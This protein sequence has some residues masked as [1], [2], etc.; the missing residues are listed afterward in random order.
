[1]HRCL[2]LFYEQIFEQQLFS[3]FTFPSS[4]LSTG[5]S[6]PPSLPP[7][8]PSLPSSPF[9]SLSLSSS[10]FPPYLPQSCPLHLPR[11]L[12]YFACQRSPS[13]VILS[14]WETQHQTSGDVDSLACALEEIDRAPSPGTLTPLGQGSDRPDSEFS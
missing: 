2:F 5:L 9:H 8:H 1:M 10:S 12:S 13:A 14:L 4:P 7:T 11:N 6:L 3:I